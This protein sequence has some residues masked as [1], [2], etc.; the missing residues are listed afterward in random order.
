MSADALLFL[1]SIEGT[2]HR[3]FAVLAPLS[4]DGLQWRP[5]AYGANSLA[6]LATH[7]LVNAEENLL[8]T[9]CRD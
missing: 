2:L 4:V 7:T 5:P 3:L 9:L 8:A 6:T 1:R